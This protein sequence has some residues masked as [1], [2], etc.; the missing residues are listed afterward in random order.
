[1]SK[2]DIYE[3]IKKIYDGNEK[4]KNNEDN[5]KTKSNVKTKFNKINLN[6][7]VYIN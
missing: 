2:G 6:E 5:C 1:M 4:K 7:E 3:K